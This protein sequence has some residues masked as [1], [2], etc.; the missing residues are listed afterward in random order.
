MEIIKGDYNNDIHQKNIINL[1]NEYMMDQMGISK[2]MP[3]RIKENLIPQLS[4]HPAAFTLLAKQDEQY[5][6]LVNCFLGLS[7]FQA[8]KLINIH[9]LIV[10]PAYRDKGIGRLLLRAVE[11]EAKK[12]NCCKITLEVRN[13][14]Y[15]AQHLYQ[16]EGY[17]DGSPPMLFWNKSLEK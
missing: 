15:K 5:V 17:H 13:D 8:R 4:D 10:L 1:M 14:N 11:K 2:P 7:T 3:D 6:G 16:S 9:D 12:L